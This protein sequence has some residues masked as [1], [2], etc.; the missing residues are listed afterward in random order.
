MTSITLESLGV[1]NEQLID[2]VVESL[3]HAFSEEGGYVTD[4]I[5]KKLDDAVEAK[6]SKRINDALGEAI[7]KA[8]DHAV[9]P[10]D[11]WGD[12]TGEPSTIREQ[13]AARAG[14]FWNEP[15]DSK[16]N[17]CS[18][19]TGKPRYKILMRNLMDDA[20][21][22]AVKVNADEIVASF[23]KS[24]KADLTASVA[25]HVDS[26]FRGKRC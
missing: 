10:C 2:R 7:T 21:T 26:A 20:F 8:L 12:A 13:L 23:R 6:L 19:H 15:V 3:C 5:K 25:K 14:K 1:T 18:Y 9:Q 4:I 24:V 16:G 22:E 17:P 11:I